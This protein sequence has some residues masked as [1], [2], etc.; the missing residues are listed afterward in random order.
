MKAN[1]SVLYILSLIQLNVRH[2]HRRLPEDLIILLISNNFKDKW[3]HLASQAILSMKN[4]GD[5]I[6]LASPTV[7]KWADDQ[8]LF[9]S[10]YSK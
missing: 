1:Q 10:P 5:C 2:T 7:D 3:V 8:N 6:I 9:F 4:T